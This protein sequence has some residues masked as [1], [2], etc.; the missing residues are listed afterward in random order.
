MY[1]MY[2]I[3]IW[4]SKV[5]MKLI[6][7]SNGWVNELVN[8]INYNRFYKNQRH[9]SQQGHPTMIFFTVDYHGNDIISSVIDH[10]ATT[11]TWFPQ[12]R[13][14]PYLLLIYRTIITVSLTLHD[15]LFHHIVESTEQLFCLKLLINILQKS[16]WAN[17]PIN[18]LMM[19]W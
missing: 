12:L 19:L 13:C 10:I 2:Y 17:L 1:V 8:N 18:L 11:S 16:P 5:Y 15:H 7:N 4:K 3:I 9:I 14:L 6:I